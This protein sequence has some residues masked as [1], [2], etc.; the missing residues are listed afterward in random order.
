[1]SDFRITDEQ[2]AQF[3]ADGYLHVRALL[4]EDE[5]AMLQ[6]AA[7]QDHGMLDSAFGVDDRKGNPV[8]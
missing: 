3:D 8:N 2:I 7:R 1:M 6:H 5:T 4:D